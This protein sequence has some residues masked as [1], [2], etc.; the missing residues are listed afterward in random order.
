MTLTFGGSPTPERRLVSEIVECWIALLNLLAAKVADARL[1]RVE[2]RGNGDAGER[3][4]RAAAPARGPA[5]R[6]GS[7]RAAAIRG[8]RPLR[9]A[10]SARGSSSRRPRCRTPACPA[11]TGRGCRSRPRRS[12][13][14]DRARRS[15]LA[16]PLGAERRRRS[17]RRARPSGSRRAS[18]GTFCRFSDRN[19]ISWT[20]PEAFHV[21]R[22]APPDL[23]VG[24]LGAERIVLPARRIGRDDVHVMQQQQRLR[25]SRRPSAARGR[26][27]GPGRSRSA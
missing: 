14:R 1:H 26:S 9:R 25:R 24:D 12:C 20:T 2:R 23:A 5:D 16:H 18:S 22:A 17:P 10:A 15:G 13:T 6:S 7:D 4:A 8:R 27:S 19:A 3:L 21:D 11:R